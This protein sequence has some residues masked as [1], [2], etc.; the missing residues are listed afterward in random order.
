[1]TDWDKLFSQTTC[2]KC[3]LEIKKGEGMIASGGVYHKST[4]Y[5]QVQQQFIDSYE[6]DEDDTSYTD[7]TIC[8]YCGYKNEDSF[9]LSDDEETVVCCRCDSEFNYE[10]IVTIQYTTTRKVSIPHR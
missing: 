6:W 10:R 4:C 5:K 2:D 8:P 9:E 3:G 1:M 7:E